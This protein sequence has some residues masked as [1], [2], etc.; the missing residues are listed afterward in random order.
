MHIVDSSEIKFAQNDQTE[1]WVR[2]RKRRQKN[3]TKEGSSS[4][5]FAGGEDDHM[6]ITKVN[7]KE[8]DNSHLKMRENSN[9]NREEDT[10]QDLKII[11][12]T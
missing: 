7:L 9:M 3:K 6:R 10:M 4:T 12:N 11:D 1:D 8:I 5:L 2:N